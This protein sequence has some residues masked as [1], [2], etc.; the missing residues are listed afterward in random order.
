VEAGA[1]RPPKSLPKQE[2]A[3]ALVSKPPPR[4]L[5][6]R[7]FGSLPAEA[8]L[9]QPKNSPAASCSWVEAG[10]FRPPKSRPK[11]KWALARVSPVFPSRD[12]SMAQSERSAHGVFSTRETD[13]QCLPGI[14]QRIA[15][16][17]MPK[18]P[19][20]HVVDRSPADRGD[21]AQAAQREPSSQGPGR[22]HPT[23]PPTKSS[24]AAISLGY[25]QP[26]T[27]PRVGTKKPVRSVM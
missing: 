13:R 20:V 5:G 15:S 22:E 8:T 11:Q 23:N 16:S 27:H 24:L 14:V 7:C 25:K 19:L 9:A 4:L 1:F 3:L 21:L 12:G 26:K 2:W 6:P 18:R 10:A 17:R